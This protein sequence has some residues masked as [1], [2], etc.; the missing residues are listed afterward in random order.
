LTSLLN[1]KGIQIE[2]I[3]NRHFKVTSNTDT[4][5]FSIP[6]N[7]PPLELNKW[8]AVFINFSNLFKQLTLNIW[9]L[10]WNEKTNMPATTDLKL[11]YN[12]T[13]SLQKVERTSDLAY[14]LKPSFM[15]ITNL[16]LFNKVAET[17]KQVFILNQNI[18]KDSQWV[19]ISDNALP[20]DRRP[21]ISYTR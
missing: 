10:Q 14:R 3:E 12:R 18:V 19:L 21:Y 5:Y 8:Y 11:I 17:D 13:V 4:Y 6:T 20:Q 9:S 16:R 7:T 15:K 1:G 2:L